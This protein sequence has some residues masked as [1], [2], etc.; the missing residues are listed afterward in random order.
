MRRILSIDGG[1][2]RGVIPAAFLSAI[3]E[4]TGKRVVDNFDLVVGTSTGGIIALALGLGLSAHA[5]LDFYVIDGPAVFDQESSNTIGGRAGGVLRRYW[6]KARRLVRPKYRVERLEAAL[7]RALGDHC[8]GDSETR[9]VIPA[10]DPE[11]RA[12]HVFKTSHH[13]RFTVDWKVPAVDVALATAAAPTYFP[14]HMID[15]GIGLIDGGVWANNPV[16]LA[17]VEALGVLN[18]QSDDLFVLSLGC[19]DQPSRIPASSGLSGFGL[20]AV[21]V[22]LLGQSLAAIGTAK[23]LTNHSD[24]RRRLYRYDPIVASGTFSIDSVARID[25][26]KGL[27]AGLAREAAPELS[28]TF[29]QQKRE[30]FLPFHG[31]D[32]TL[33][34]VPLFVPPPAGE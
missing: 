21:E 22:M 26:L 34:T 12:V 13:E 25:V 5:V 2:I 32:A 29:F 4:A 19:A 3:E 30:P 27:G 16:G 20:R 28:R 11:R 14:S 6:H 15:S 10:F 31:R 7:R 18:W 23:L 17:V 33:G 24:E 9:L 1:G 8:L